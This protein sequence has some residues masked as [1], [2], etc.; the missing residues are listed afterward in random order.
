MNAFDLIK[1]PASDS[2]DGKFRDTRN[3]TVYTNGFIDRDGI[4]RFFD[5]HDITYVIF[6]PDTLKYLEKIEE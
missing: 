5:I 1:K 6:A 4:Y 2:L 3:G